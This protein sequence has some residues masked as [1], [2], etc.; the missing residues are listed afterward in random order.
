MNWLMNTALDNAFFIVARMHKFTSFIPLVNLLQNR[1]E[2]KDTRGLCSAEK[3]FIFMHIFMISAKARWQ[4]S[5]SIISKCV[6]QVI[7]SLLKV[8][9][10]LMEKPSSDKSV[11]PSIADNPKFAPFF[12]NCIGATDGSLIHAIIPTYK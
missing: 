6:H 2:L 9:H 12:N 10:L 3:V 4:H 8:R 1:G 5:L 7:D 11:N